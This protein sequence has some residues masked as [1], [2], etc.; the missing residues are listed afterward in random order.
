SKS[1]S[2]LSNVDAGVTANELMRL[3]DSSEKEA[4]KAQLIQKHGWDQSTMQWLDSLASSPEPA[5]AEPCTK[6]MRTKWTAGQDIELMD[7]CP[8]Y[9]ALTNDELQGFMHKHG[10]TLAAV[11]VH[12][13]VLLKNLG[14]L[15]AGEIRPLSS[16]EQKII[17]YAADQR[18]PDAVRF[19]D[20]KEQLSTRSFAEL[21]HLTKHNATKAASTN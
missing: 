7:M 2:Q 13:S 9:R 19:R 6:R 20:V 18:K 15:S 11:R 8:L 16:S 4:M 1:I 12:L 10:R 3:A 5:L 17:A 21:M 14:G